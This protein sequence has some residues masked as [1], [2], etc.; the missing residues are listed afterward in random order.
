MKKTTFFLAAAAILASCNREEALSSTDSG[1]S[2]NLFVKNYEASELQGMITPMAQ[3][4]GLSGKAAGVQANYTYRG[5]AEPV[6]LDLTLSGIAGTENL[7]GAARYM[8]LS[9]SAAWTVNDIV[10]VV[11]H[12]AEVS[13]GNGGFQ[14][15][16]SYNVNGSGPKV[17]GSITA[18]KQV[19]IG[20]YEFK[21]RVDFFDADYHEVYGDVNAGSGNYEIMMA[22]QRSTATSGYLLSG[23]DGAVVT[24]IDYDYVNDEFWEGSFREIPLP[25]RSANDIV[26]A[27]RR[28]YVTTGDAYGQGT[29]GVYELD[30]NLINV[31]KGASLSNG[32][33]GRSI[34]IDNNEK[35]PGTENTDQ[36]FV[37]GGSLG[38]NFEIYRQFVS[39]NPGISATNFALGTPLNLATPNVTL[40]NERGDLTIATSPDDPFRDP[41]LNPIPTRINWSPERTFITLNS[42]N[43]GA[44]SVYN[45]VSTGTPGVYTLGVIPNI[46]NAISTEYDP[47]LDVLYVA[48]G[49]DVNGKA[50]KVIALDRFAGQSPLINDYDVVGEFADPAIGSKLLSDGVT[51]MT[52]TINDVKEITIYGSRNIAV[53]AGSQGV[54]FIQRDKF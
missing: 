31:N 24:R 8:D 48:M 6:R 7:S 1:N 4:F 53:A 41:N 11:W 12:A 32:Y 27:A 36:L 21:D 19:G 50:V 43:F 17:G 15:S 25:G 39:W 35:L 18:Y 16:G 37:V 49:G 29:G 46:G 5:W 20:Q 13:D 23:H 52:P 26:G 9:A 28:F 54:Y 14:N 30:R 44:E 38:F 42:V 3:S 47:A 40:N 51:T 45:L 34:A 10:F 2:G 22:G 33:S